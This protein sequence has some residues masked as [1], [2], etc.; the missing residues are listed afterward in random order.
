MIRF[1]NLLAKDKLAALLEAGSIGIPVDASKHFHAQMQS[2]Q[3]R[4]KS[5]GVWRW[6]PVKQGRPNHLWD[7]ADMAVVAACV[8]KVLASV[9]EVKV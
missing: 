7:C 8:F 3:R 2:E 4:E 9:E 6:E 1:S 5:P